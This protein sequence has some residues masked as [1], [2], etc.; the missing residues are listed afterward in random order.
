MTSLKILKIRLSDGATVFDVI[1]KDDSANQLF[2]F[3]CYS[4]QD[5]SRF[6]AQ[7]ERLINEHTTQ[8]AQQL[9]E[10]EQ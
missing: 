4:L 9:Q 3:A 1:V 5:A 8:M 2:R 7:L 6:A 10:I